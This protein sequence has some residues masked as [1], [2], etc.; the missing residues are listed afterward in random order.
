MTKLFRGLLPL[1]LALMA[2]SLALAETATVT[3]SPAVAVW[4]DTVK[5]KIEGVGCTRAASVPALKRL[6]NG[7][8][9]YD[10]DLLSCPD[11]STTPFST[12]V[13]MGPL[14]QQEY[15]VRVYNVA[16]HVASPNAPP[17]ASAPLSIHREAS[18]DV[19]LE[20]VATDEAPFT[21][22]FRGSAQSP[23]FVF[24]PP[25]VEGKTITARLD[26]DCPIIPAN[27]PTV[28]SE[29]ET[30]GPLP[31]GEYEV[32]FFQVSSSP[33]LMLYRRTLTVY[34]SHSCVPSAT[35]LCLQNNRF[36]VEVAWKD[37]EGHTGSGHAVPLEV[38]DDSGLFWFFQEANIE[39]T[40]KVLDG[41]SYNGSWW[42][43]LSSGS[44]VEYK[45]IVTDTKTGKKKE[46]L[47]VLG[48]SAPLVA[49][50]A[51]FSC[52]P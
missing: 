33:D 38:G 8:Y 6:S 14:A 32:N 11:G 27:A 9:A 2:V 3:L 30:L 12:V 4:N 41:C 18:L 37:F 19:L 44:T 50:T 52:A 43:F 10:I 5:V 39:L 1:S 36:R 16:R 20:G 15:T 40:A 7:H 51:A 34:D 22:V 24:N 49:D 48:V 13:E 28:V 31:A 17:L 45:V 25:V 46:Y 29:A 35:A 21:L 23:C 42:V 47:N 26:D